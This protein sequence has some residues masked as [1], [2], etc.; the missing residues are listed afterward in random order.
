MPAFDP[1]RDAVLNSPIA[2]QSDGSRRQ[3]FSHPSPSPTSTHSPDAF[4]PRRA[5]DLSVLLNASIARPSSPLAPPPPPPLPLAIPSSHIRPSSLAHILHSNANE[6]RSSPPPDRLSRVPALQRLGS[7][8]SS[9]SG[10]VQPLPAS[11]PPPFHPTI[12]PQVRPLSSLPQ[13]RTRTPTSPDVLFT[14]ISER[15]GLFTPGVER[16]SSGGYFSPS[17]DHRGSG[18]LFT[19]IID[20]RSGGLFTPTVEQRAGV[21][22]TPGIDQRGVGALFT[23]VD[24]QRPFTFSHPPSPTNTRPRT[25]SGSQSRPTSSHRERPTSSHRERPASSHRERPTSSHRERF[26]PTSPTMPP[27]PPPHTGRIPSTPSPALVPLSRLPTTPSPVLPT[28]PIP[29]HRPAHFPVSTIPTRGPS[30]PRHASPPSLKQSLHSPDLVKMPARPPSSGLALPTP[31]VTAASVTP[32]TP[33]PAQPRPATSRPTSSSG[34]L[35]P[36]AVPPQPVHHKPAPPTPVSASPP[37]SDM[38]PAPTRK[39]ARHSPSPPPARSRPP[40]RLPASLPPRPQSPPPP[41]KPDPTK[42]TLPY[43]PRRR[44]PA[45]SVLIPLSPDEI[46]MYRAQLGQ[47]TLRLAKRKRPMDEMELEEQNLGED[48]PRVK[49]S[50]D[51][52]LVVE[53]Y[54]ARPNVGVEQRRDSPIIGLRNFNNWIKSVLITRFAQ[55][56]LQASAVVSAPGRGGGGLRGKVLDLG[57]GKGGDLSKW[58]KSKVKEYAGLDIAAISVDQARSRHGSLRPPRSDAIFAAL[59]CY[60]Y[61]LTRALPPARLAMPFDVVSMQFCMHYAFESL[62]KA[63]RMLE[64]ASTWLR[65]GGVMVGTIPNAEQLLERLDALPADT[66][67]LMF[68]NEVYHIKFDDREN[69]PIYGHRYSFFLKDA[70]EDVP[71]YVVHWESFVQLAAEYHLHPIYKKEFHDVFQEFQDHEEFKPLLQRMK[72]VDINGETEMDEDQWEAA[73]TDRAVARVDIYIA[74]AMEK[75]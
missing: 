29:H 4:G 9:S 67:E 69:R 1:V 37:P 73:T 61:P 45:G 13:L 46:A 50:R 5:T 64:N 71:E 47:G 34:P 51:A 57:C 63:R 48:A 30:P 72:V 62:A 35:P 11:F 60:V 3:S 7:S 32:V 17:I 54:N 53:H 20:Q 58:A 16:A 27:P 44:T 70:V 15:G 75:R 8:S 59:D 43:N 49:R 68:G 41:P 39:R 40:P 24:L 6:H 25:Q 19:P 28:T 23:P 36:P 38:P 66:E 52:G 31:P 74:F 33:A 22:H 2:Q 55:P 12:S 42:K 14:P 65:P 26:P 18:P 21:P 56:A 10:G